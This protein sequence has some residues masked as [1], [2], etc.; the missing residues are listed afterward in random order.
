MYFI[1]C[2]VIVVRTPFSLSSSSFLFVLG[3]SCSLAG[4]KKLAKCGKDR[5]TSSSKYLLSTLEFH[6]SIR[7]LYL[8]SRS[9]SPTPLDIAR[10]IMSSPIKLLLILFVAA[11]GKS[12]TDTPLVGESVDMDMGGDVAEGMASQN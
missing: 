3:A 2:I 1:P 9:L 12:V 10:V 11:V 6:V 8:I 5:T 4:L 7:T